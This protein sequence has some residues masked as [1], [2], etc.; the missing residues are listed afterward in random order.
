MTVDRGALLDAVRADLGS[1]DRDPGEGDADPVVL[2]RV[3]GGWIDAIR[4]GGA[5]PDD[6]LDAVCRQ[7]DVRHRLSAT[8]RPGWRRAE[9]ETDAP[10][11][12]VVAAVAALLASAERS[13]DEGRRLKQVNSALKALDLRDEQP[14]TPALRAWAVELLDRATAEDG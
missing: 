3:V 6:D 2:A 10:V 14:A 11:G 4:S 9:P 8:Y 7:I 1:P 5:V 12:V 13:G